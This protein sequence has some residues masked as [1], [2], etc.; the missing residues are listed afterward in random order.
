MGN[1]FLYACRI[2]SCHVLACSVSAVR[3]NHVHPP[4]GGAHL[5]VVMLLVAK[6]MIYSSPR[7][8]APL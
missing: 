7:Q 4:C 5:L 2:S 8:Q 1:L 3:I 6:V